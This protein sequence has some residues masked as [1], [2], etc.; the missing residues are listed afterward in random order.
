MIEKDV[1]DILAGKH[2]HDLFISHCKTG[3]WQG[4]AILDAWVMPYS[5]TKPIIGYEV[6]IN[7]Q[8]FR[9]DKKWEKYLEYCNIFYFVTPWGLINIEEVP[10]EA[11]LIWITKTKRS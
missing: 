4:N 10:S 6:K 2:T 3:P 1:L 5:W 9:R 7:R 11:G 8:D